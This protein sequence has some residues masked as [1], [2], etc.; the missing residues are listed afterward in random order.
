V[1]KCSVLHQIREDGYGAHYNIAHI[2][3]VY[4]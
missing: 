4:G 2:R 1:L 3:H